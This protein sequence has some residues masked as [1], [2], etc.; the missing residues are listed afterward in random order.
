MIIGQGSSDDD[1]TSRVIV[2]ADEYIIYSVRTI[3]GWKQAQSV[4]SK[5]FK[6]FFDIKLVAAS[7]SRSSQP[8]KLPSSALAIDPHDVYISNEFVASFDS[9][10]VDYGLRCSLTV[11]CNSCVLLH[12]VLLRAYVQF[13]CSNEQVLAVQVSVGRV[14]EYELAIDSNELVNGRWIHVENHFPAWLDVNVFSFLWHF[15]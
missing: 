8:R 4:T 6:A 9:I 1:F 5:Q 7:E 14:V 10:I 3:G 13:A 2:R 15:A 12:W 11:Q